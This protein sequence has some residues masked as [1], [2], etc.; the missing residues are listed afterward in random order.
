[1]WPDLVS[2][3]GP[4]TLSS[5][6]LPTAPRGPARSLIRAA[7]SFSESAAQTCVGDQNQI[8]TNVIRPH[9]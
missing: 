2:N 9:I 1:M 3:P 5:D 6:A 7:L 8:C 4:L